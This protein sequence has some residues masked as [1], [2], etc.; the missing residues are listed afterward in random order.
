MQTLLENNSY[1]YKLLIYYHKP[2]QQFIYIVFTHNSFSD[3]SKLQSYPA[4]NPE[5][6]FWVS[7]HMKMCENWLDVFV[8]ANTWEKLNNEI[9]TIGT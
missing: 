8:S 6:C 4:R 1:T 7:W 9:E 2:K 3:S 5:W